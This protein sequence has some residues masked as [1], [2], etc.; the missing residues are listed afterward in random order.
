MI[1]TQTRKMPDVIK[2]D[3]PSSRVF[4][5]SWLFL[6]CNSKQIQLL[7]SYGSVVNGISQLSTFYTLIR[8]SQA[9][10]QHCNH[11]QYF[12]WEKHQPVLRGHYRCRC[13]FCWR[14]TGAD[15]TGWLCW[16]VLPRFGDSG[17]PGASQDTNKLVCWLSS[18]RLD[19]QEYWIHWK[20][21][22][23]FCRD[24]TSCRIRPFVDVRVILLH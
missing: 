10:P 22:G 2:W 18:W 20:G 13:G 11:E 6:L 5:H 14:E 24:L 21:K 7:I 16:G 17:K 19:S 9:S 23:T 4:F 3:L 15:G 8:Y 12:P 1:I